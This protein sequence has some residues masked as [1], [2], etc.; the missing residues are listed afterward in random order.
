VRY[1]KRFADSDSTGNFDVIRDLV[2]PEKHH[3]T[4]PGGAA[5]VVVCGEQVAVSVAE[6]ARLG[7]NAGVYGAVPTTGKFVWNFEP[8]ERASEGG[9]H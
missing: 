8:D 5:N 2:R 3:S 9:I 4:P 6:A 1:P 7:A